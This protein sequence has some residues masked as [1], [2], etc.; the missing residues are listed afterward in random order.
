[1]SDMRGKTACFTGHREIE[2]KEICRLRKNS[3]FV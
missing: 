3:N 1:M 2:K